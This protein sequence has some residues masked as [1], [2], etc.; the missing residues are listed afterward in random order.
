MS[1]M[2]L[3]WVGDDAMLRAMDAYAGKVLSAVRQVAEYWKGQWEADAKANAPWQDQTGNARQA[4]HAGIEE[5]AHDA[6]RLYL[7]HG[8]NYGLWLE[9]RFA[10][11]WSIIWP[12]IEASLPHIRAMLQGIFG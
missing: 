4:L 8:V 3:N 9:V 6:V 12:T 5:M 1:A 11:R 10:G 7:S 2:S